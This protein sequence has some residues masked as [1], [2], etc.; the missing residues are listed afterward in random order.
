MHRVRSLQSVDGALSAEARRRQSL[1]GE[2]KEAPIQS[3]T[4]SSNH[5]SLCSRLLRPATPE[6]C[7]HLPRAATAG[8]FPRLPSGQAAHLRALQ[9][10][11]TR[12]RALP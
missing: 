5:A 11:F 6:R 12:K 1:S 8:R 2:K 9:A 7:R 10:V 3:I 4:H